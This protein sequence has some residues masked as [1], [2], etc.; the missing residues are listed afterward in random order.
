M[1]QRKH[2][3]PDTLLRF[4]RR[5]ATRAESLAVVRHLLTGCRKCLAVTRPVWGFA[6]E[7]LSPEGESCRR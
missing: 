7:R 4:L 6:D 1:G 5:E 3:R 2:P